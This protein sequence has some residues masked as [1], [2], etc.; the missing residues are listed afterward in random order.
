M[1]LAQNQVTLIGYLGS[2][3]EHFGEG[4][5]AG[6]RFSLATTETFGREEERKE[7]TDW[8]RIV[9][10]NGTARACRHLARGDRLAV[11]GKLRTND[12]TDEEGN[13]RRTVEVQALDVHFLKVKAFAKGEPAEDEPP[14]KRT[15]RRKKA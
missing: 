2:D 15:R 1:N 12:W 4:E 3:P 5:R 13:A 14:K 6:A 9:A 11:F 10:W 7:R 8:H